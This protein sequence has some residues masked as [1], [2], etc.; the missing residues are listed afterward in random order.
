MVQDLRHVPEMGIM[1]VA[2]SIRIP[3]PESPG[4]ITAVP[5]YTF[6]LAAAM[7]PAARNRRDRSQKTS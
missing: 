3:A 1:E 6:F 4:R 5:A 2:F 7:V